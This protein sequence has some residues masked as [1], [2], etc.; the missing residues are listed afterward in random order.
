MELKLT[1]PL[2]SVVTLPCKKLSGQLCSFTA[3]LVQ[4]EVMQRRLITV[5]VH[6]GF[7]FF[8]LLYRLI[9]NM[10]FKCLLSAHMHVLIRAHHWS[11]DASTVHCS[12]LR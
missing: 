11:M 1:P 4:H 9:Y 10:C 7:C 12:M 6:Q 8:V 5:N 3:Q 2:K